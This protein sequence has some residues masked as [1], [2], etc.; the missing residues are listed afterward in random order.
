MLENNY[1][2]QKFDTIL[3]LLAYPLAPLCHFHKG[4][5][6][7]DKAAAYWFYQAANSGDADAQYKIAVFFMDGVGVEEDLEAAHYWFMQA[8]LQGDADAQY[9][10]GICYE[11]G[12]G[13]EKDLD[14]AFD[15]YTRSA[16]QGNKNAKRA[17]NDKSQSIS[18][19]NPNS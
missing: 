15:W 9:S 14:E 6:K 18:V 8:A 7:D 3:E 2:E 13:V 19:P 17:S 12:L 16:A 11:E 10:L 4:V 1:F 5:E